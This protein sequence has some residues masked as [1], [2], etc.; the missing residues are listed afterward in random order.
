MDEKPSLDEALAH[1]GVK[2]MKWGQHKA[3]PSGISRKQNRQ[4]NRDARNDF[5]NKKLSYLLDEARKDDK[6]LIKAHTYEDPYG[7]VVSGREF[8][9]N[10]E[11][12][13]MLDIKMTEIWARRSDNPLD[14]NSPKQVYLYEPQEKKIGSY[15]KQDFRTKK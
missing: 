11:R 5:N 14:K 8:V 12:G 10:M 15:K 4:M 6:I 9:Y 13:K 3:E 2:G 7:I 1:F